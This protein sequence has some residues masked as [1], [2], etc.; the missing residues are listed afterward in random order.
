MAYKIYGAERIGTEWRFLATHLSNL[1]LLLCLYKSKVCLAVRLIPHPAVRIWGTAGG[2]RELRV[3]SSKR[4]MLLNSCH[5]CI[6][7]KT[8]H[9][10]KV[11]HGANHVC[12]QQ[13][14]T[15]T[16]FVF[17]LFFVTNPAFMIPYINHVF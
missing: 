3:Q 15:C 16:C 5:L 11:E 10:M 4:K 12:G 17:S 1:F 7:C 9:Y 14:L 8:G 6:S 13:K 2:T